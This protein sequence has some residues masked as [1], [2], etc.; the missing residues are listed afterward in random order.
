MAQDIVV[1]LNRSDTSPFYSR[2]QSAVAESKQAKASVQQWLGMIKGFSQKGV[3]GIEMEESGVLA[4]LESLPPQDALT[5]TELLHEIDRRIV[6]VKEVTLGVPGFA[7]WRHAGGKYQ[8]VLYIANSERAN[9]DDELELIEYRMEELAFDL[10]KAIDEPDLLVGLE[11]RRESLLTQQSVAI[12]FP[13]HHFSDK[14]NGKHGRNLL[15]HVR[16]TVREDSGIYFIEEIQSDW[17]QRG[18][19]SNW[20]GIPKGPFVTNTEAWTGLVLRRHL[21]IAAKNPKITQVAW[22]TESMRNGGEQNLARE[23]AQEEAAARRAAFI[24]DH[25]KQVLDKMDGASLNKE[26][27]A[28]VKAMARNQAEAAADQAGLRVGEGL[29]AFYLKMIPKLVDKLINGTGEKTTIRQIDLAGSKV[30]VPCFAMTPAVRDKLAAPQP[31][32]SR[33]RLTAAAHSESDPALAALVRECGQMIGSVKHIRLL[34]HVYDIATGKPVAGR[35]S[36]AGEGV[37]MASLGAKDV[38]EVLNHECYHFAEDRLMSRA[39]AQMVHAAFAPGGDLHFRV[40]EALVARGDLELA[41][42]CQH[43]QEAAAQGFALWRKG[44]L[45]MTPPKV[46]GVFSDIVNAF[47]DVVAWLREKVMDQKLQTPQQ[48]FEALANGDLAHRQLDE[49]AR[50]ERFGVGANSY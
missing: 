20:N 42:H 39:E 1:Y 21:Q 26:Q 5:R 30:E 8:E 4:W 17:A 14:V 11:R 32:Y 3:K 15:A 45:D 10:D 40:Q 25:E 7:Q 31:L 41:R 43:P 49:V 46:T 23:R 48:V 22:I 37:V 44:L 35:Y 36:G 24:A 28:T 9:I 6:T 2:L 33:A 50:R 34:T 16:V 47:R 12:D 19:R 29:N 18:R 27:L 13:N 38:D